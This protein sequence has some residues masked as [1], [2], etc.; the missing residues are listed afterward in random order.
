MHQ[1]T[2]SRSAFALI[3]VVL[4]LLVFS[5]ILSLTFI[6]SSLGINGSAQAVMSGA[7]A[8]SLAE[9]CM[10]AA[11]YEIR[12]DMDYDPD[13]ITLSTGKCDIDVE[14][15]DENY[16]VTSQA[17]KNGYIRSTSVEVDRTT[18][19]LILRSWQVR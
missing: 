9:G 16:R 12:S 18:T 5:V 11:L 17:E 15:N 4:G 1:V 10:E 19:S 8:L 2:Q 6:R 3:S 13:E 14:R 7:Q